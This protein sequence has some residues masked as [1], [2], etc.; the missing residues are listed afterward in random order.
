MLPDV[1]VNLS[2]NIASGLLRHRVVEANDLRNEA[3]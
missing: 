3:C 2:D 1:L